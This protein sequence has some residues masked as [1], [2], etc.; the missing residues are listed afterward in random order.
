MR[1][2]DEAV[3]YP[4]KIIGRGLFSPTKRAWTFASDILEGP[5]ERSKAVPPRLEGNFGDGHVGIAKERFCPLYS[6][7][8]KIAVRREPEGMFE[9]PREMGLGDTAHT[10]EAL[11]R[12]LL[13]RGGI[14]AVLC[15][16][17]PAKETRILP[18]TCACHSS[19]FAAAAQPK[20]ATPARRSSEPR[21]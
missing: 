5:T 6:A 9:R 20:S 17:Q 13:V 3:R 7:C 1:R 11:D 4:P 15:A 19:S 2:A 18:G 8:Q 21:G 12:P 10:R 14:H 16:Q